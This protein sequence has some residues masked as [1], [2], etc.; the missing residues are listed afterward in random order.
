MMVG[1]LITRGTSSFN[2]PKSISPIAFVNTYVFGHP[3]FLALIKINGEINY[4]NNNNI[5][6][7]KKLLAIKLDVDILLC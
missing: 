3:Y 1:R 4:N 2:F 6:V 7:Q 5:H